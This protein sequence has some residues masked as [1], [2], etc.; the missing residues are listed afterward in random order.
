MLVSRIQVFRLLIQNTTIN[1]THFYNIKRLVVFV[2]QGVFYDQKVQDR[3][4]VLTY[5]GA[6]LYKD[7]YYFNTI[8]SVLRYHLDG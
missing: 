8:A 6:F 5:L 3:V 2:S 4:R 1:L 7:S